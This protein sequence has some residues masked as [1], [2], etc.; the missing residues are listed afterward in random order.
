MD[1]FP[2]VTFYLG[3]IQHLSCIVHQAHLVCTMTEIFPVCGRFLHGA[4]LPIM[5]V[6]V[7]LNYSAEVNNNNHY[8]I[9]LHQYNNYKIII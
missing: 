1:L 4:A 5:L 2:Y 3:V 6:I 9:T 7:S 8:N